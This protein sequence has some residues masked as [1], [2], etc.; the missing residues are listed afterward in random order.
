M[1]WT[2]S[3]QDVSKIESSHSIVAIRQPQLM[4]TTWHHLA[5]HAQCAIGPFG[6]LGLNC[7]AILR[8]WD[9][10]QITLRQGT[11]CRHFRDNFDPTKNNIRSTLRQLYDNFDTTLEN[12]DTTLRQHC[13]DTS[14]GNFIKLWNNLGNFLTTL[15]S[16]GDNWQSAHRPCGQHLT[17]SFTSAAKILISKTLIKQA[18]EI[19]AFEFVFDFGFFL[20]CWICW[21]KW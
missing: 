17:I 6:Q 1:A 18:L 13:I 12:L 14:L 19:L 4:D 11:I 9:N 2:L 21:F 3:Q 5:L 15:G 7:G 10:F 16:H 20:Q 8:L